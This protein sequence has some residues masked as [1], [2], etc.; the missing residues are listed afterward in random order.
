MGEGMKTAEQ[1]V[2]EVLDRHLK[3]IW[4]GDLATYTATTGEDVT[5]LSGTSV[6]SASMGWTFT[7][8][9][10]QPTPAWPRRNASRVDVM[11]SNMRCCS[12]RSSFMVLSQSSPIRC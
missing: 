9:K 7:Y 10:P 4:A 2:L 1:E 12:P 5:F 3:S 11:R 8:G 6:L